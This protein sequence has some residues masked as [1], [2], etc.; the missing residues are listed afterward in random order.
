[1]VREN[2]VGVGHRIVRVLHPRLRC[3]D[4]ERFIGAGHLI[5]VFIDPVT[6]NAVASLITIKGNSMLF[7]HFARGYSRRAR[8]NDTDAIREL[9]HRL[10]PFLSLAEPTV[11]MNI[12]SLEKAFGEVK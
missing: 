3:I 12:T 8:T 11:R 4:E 7:E 1:M 9:R 5:V 10:L 2:R 6:A